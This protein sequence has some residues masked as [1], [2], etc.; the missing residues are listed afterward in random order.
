MLPV[1]LGCVVFLF[2]LSSSG[3]PY[4]T[5]FSRLCC[6]VAFDE[7]KQNKNTTQPRET[8]NIGYTRQRK[9]KQQHNTT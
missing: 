8:D 9:T 5:S 6:V 4:V 7:D 3:V 1:S 2:C